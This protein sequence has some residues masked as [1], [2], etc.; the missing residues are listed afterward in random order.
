MEKERVALS[1][2]SSN[3]QRTCKMLAKHRFFDLI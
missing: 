1:D 2:G 3:V